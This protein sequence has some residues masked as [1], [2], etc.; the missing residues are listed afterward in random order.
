MGKVEGGDTA[1][2]VDELITKLQGLDAGFDPAVVDGSW[3]LVFTRNSNDAPKVQAAFSF[4][5]GYQNFDTKECTFRNIAELYGKRVQL[6]A[7]VS[8]RPDPE[9]PSRLISD[10]VYAGLHLGPLKIPLPLRATG[11]LEFVY[12]DSELR[13]TRGNRGG[14]FVHI[15]PPFSPEERQALDDRLSRRSLELDPAGY[16]IISAD[17]NRQEIK[18]SH[19]P[20]TINEKGLA[21]DPETGEVIGC[22]DSAPIPVS[23]VFR[24]RTAKEIAVRV[25]EE[26]EP[27]P[28][29]KFEHAAYLGREF[30]RAEQCLTAG[31][32]YVQD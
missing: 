28:V 10:I 27:C 22:T 21:C 3:Q 29:T 23:R 13:V 19:Y 1:K 17:V 8:Y 24:G 25:L 6:I 18:A 20:N 31:M 7:D 16:F 30:Q 4:N 14:L 26:A 5:K 32:E 9:I 2:A 12:L 11:W 15:R